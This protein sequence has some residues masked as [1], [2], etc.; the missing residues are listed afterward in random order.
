MI[1]IYKLLIFKYLTPCVFVQQLHQPLKPQK[2]NSENEMNFELIT[3]L[4]KKHGGFNR[5]NALLAGY[6]QNSW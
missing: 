1:D 4:S 6:L 2:I 3:K 5:L